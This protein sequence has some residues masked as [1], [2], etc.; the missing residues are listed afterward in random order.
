MGGKFALGGI[1]LKGNHKKPNKPNKI[2][3]IFKISMEMAARKTSWF[4][5]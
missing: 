5:L 4:S 2:K 1:E 3:Y